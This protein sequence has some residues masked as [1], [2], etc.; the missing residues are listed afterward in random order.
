MNVLQQ[1]LWLGLLTLPAILLLH[2]LRE[3]SKR[4][5]IS[6]L[7]LWRWLEKELRGPRLRRLPVTW[8]L[9]LQLLAALFLNLALAQPQL[10]LARLLPSRQ[11]LIVIIDTSSSMGAQDVQPSRLAQAQAAAAARLAALGQDDQA[12]L[13]SAG[14][15]ARQLGSAEAESSGDLNGRL[16]A[17]RAAGD[18]SDWP[19]ALALAAAAIKPDL[20]NVVAVYTDGAFAMSSSSADVSL[21]A[22]VDVTLVGQPQANQ[23]IVTLSARP[24]SSGAVQVFARL[25]N[26]SE[27][28]AERTLTL[29]A[30]GRARDELVVTLPESGV[31]EQAWTLPPGV[32]SVSVSLG[33][34]GDVLPADDTAAVGV[35]GTTTLEGVL[36]TADLAAEA[37]LVL[38]RA[39]RSLP[40]LH[41]LTVTPENYAAYENYDLTVFSGV[42]PEAWPRGG[43]L[44]M[45][46]PEGIGLLN[47]QPPTPV[48][49]LPAA[50]TDPLL[51]DID[52]G[53]VDFGRGSLLEPPDWLTPVLTDERGLTLVWRG[54]TRDSRLVVFTFG[55]D[56]GNLARRTAF[57]VLMA[58]AVAEVLPPPLPESITPGQPVSLPPAH[59]L[60]FLTITDPTGAAH[61]FT[62]ERSALF[63]ETYQ[64]GLYWL[65]GRTIAGEDWQAGFGVNAGSALESDLRVSAQPLLRSIAEGG[66]LPTVE[67]NKP[68]ELWPWLVLFVLF[69]M[70]LEAG[71]SWR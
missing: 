22:S 2:L 44:V 8:V 1:W 13:I 24:S 68:E 62:G 46:P 30:D 25:A 23:A 27:A 18:G 4:Q 65:R 55:L 53:P 19:G 15:V 49:A 10:S 42:L 41:L 40:N 7:E 43:V 54:A 9:L 67:A 28:P 21:P 29:F 58:N 33:G 37:T 38:E 35:L 36:V 26:F 16:F 47:V 6:S 52:L 3:R 48:G 45:A 63:T 31:S 17:L 51:A 50:P 39:L 34:S 64:P 66:V 57:P 69:L 11:H 59:R 5:P 56:R 70:I 12:T 14:P 61:T 32:R 60:P 71:L 20:N